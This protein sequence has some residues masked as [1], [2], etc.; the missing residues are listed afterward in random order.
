MNEWDI[1]LKN[2]LKAMRGDLS[3][4][5]DEQ[6]LEY[7][8]PENDLIN[9]LGNQV[10][11]YASSTH[12]S[13]KIRIENIKKNVV[14][15]ESWS[16]I[17]PMIFSSYPEFE[18]D[19]ISRIN[20]NQAYILIKKNLLKFE[21][22]DKEKRQAW[23]AADIDNVLKLLEKDLICSDDISREKYQLLVKEAS[24]TIILKLVEKNLINFKDIPQEKQYIVAQI[25]IEKNLSLMEKR[26]IYKEYISQERLHFWVMQ[27]NPKQALLLIK[28]G[29]IFR[30]EIPKEKRQSWIPHAE[31][32]KT[33]WLLKNNLIYPEDIPKETQQSYIRQKI[34]KHGI[35]KLKK[36]F[37]IDDKDIINASSSLCSGA[38]A[39]LI[40]L[41]H[42]KEA[43]KRQTKNTSNS[44][45]INQ[46]T[47]KNQCDLDNEMQKNI[48]YTTSFQVKLFK[49]EIQSQGEICNYINKHTEFTIYIDEAWPGAIQNAVKPRNEGVIAGLICHGNSSVRFKDLPEIQ[50]H[51]YENLKS[52][53][54]YLVKLLSCNK[55]L[56]FIFPIYLPNQS[57]QAIAHYDLLL[58]QA[59]KLLLGWLLPKPIN[60]K[61]LHIYLER[62]GGHHSG[63]KRTEF[64]VGMLSQNP[65]RYGKWILDTIQWTDKEFGYI[66]YA[67]LLAHVTHEH[68][69]RNR[70]LGSWID[71]KNLPGYVPL[72]LELIPRLERLEHLETSANMDDVLDFAMETGT[73]PFGRLVLNDI[74]TRLAQRPDLQ[75]RLLDTLETC[76]QAKVRDLNSL[77][78]QFTI[79][80]QLI[81]S[82]PEVAAPR[83]RLLW[84]LLAL[85]D[86]NHDGDPERMHQSASAYAADR[87][88]LRDVDREL[89]AYADLNLAVHYADRFEFSQAE[90]TISEWVDDPLFPALSR[91]QQ[92]RMYSTLG[93]YRAMHY[94]APA[95]E[96]CF[97]KALA[98][99]QQATITAEERANE[100]DQ[101]RIYRAINALDGELP[102]ALEHTETVLGPLA[103]AART[104]AS[105][106]SVKNQYRH[107]LLLRAL[108]QCDEQAAAARTAYLDQHAQWQ[109]GAPQHPWPL[110]HLYR[111]LLLWSREEA[112][113]ETLA[114]AQSWF[115]RAI[116]ITTMETHG[117]TVKL[118][119]AM[120]AT[121]AACC[122]DDNSYVDNARKLLD[123]ARVLPAADFVI[124]E[125][126]EILTAPEPTA[127]ERALTALPFNYH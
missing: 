50:T 89:C 61:R 118:I 51:S 32:D 3:L 84:H 74:A 45:E 67:D 4:E 60:K 11:R 123:E 2:I 77:R 72:S 55:C 59:I 43:S 40:T 6:D 117:A 20:F 29:L 92:G 116:L 119:G 80:R 57:D 88:V 122:F 110:I 127:I 24:T 108:F 63:E 56:P 90:V 46:K 82:L 94:D 22:I 70:S 35:K 12:R 38:K 102:G 99:F 54:E 16:A 52:A 97:A 120:I 86:A 93:Q 8:F 64:F 85:Q 5:K 112:D 83:M 96:D 103:D 111:G 66:P 91:R 28:N 14:E 31:I 37:T 9:K 69:E 121:V 98:A 21:N 13:G 23:I 68:T 36:L 34:T 71:Y 48:D 30:E 15:K 73:S 42:P 109:D 95:A 19:I 65:N 41:T 81:P 33:S 101:T 87:A 18:I 100:Q 58:Q 106:G 25:D 44:E 78:R 26:L 125:L 114:A 124:D 10:F 27:A 126:T 17:L 62:I 1:W 104:L 39:K 75:Q 79:V 47:L 115:D 76:Y 107:H 49:N 53:K 113:E 7:S 105:D